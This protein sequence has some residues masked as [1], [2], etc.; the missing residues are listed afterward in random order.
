MNKT[1]LIAAVATA[2]AAAAAASFSLGF[3]LGPKQAL[4]GDGEIV[5]I[6]DVPARIAYRH[7]EPGAVTARAST[8]Q[9]ALVNN[10]LGNDKS[11]KGNSMAKEI[12]DNE[13][14][15]IHSGLKPSS[16]LL[17][18]TARAGSYQA[19]TQPGSISGVNP[20]QG[21]GGAL[22]GTGAAVGNLVGRGTIDIG[23]TVTGA[24]ANMHSN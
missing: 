11:Q 16:L 21:L 24:L 2:Y 10:S 1:T 8:S 22:G 3:M 6:R 5:I 15:T 19:G 17:D 14:A 20:A 9:G 12:S 4:A 13:S 18:N 23:R 7:G